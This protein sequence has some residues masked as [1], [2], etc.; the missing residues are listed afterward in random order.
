MA[1]TYWVEG[2]DQFGDHLGVIIEAEDDE[3]A[4]KKFKERF[5]DCTIIHYDSYDYYDELNDFKCSD[6][7]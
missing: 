1:K 5:S 4:I 6:Y 2:C 7:N 3:M